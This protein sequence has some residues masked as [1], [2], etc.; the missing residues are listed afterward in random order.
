MSVEDIMNSRSSADGSDSTDVSDK[1][2]PP[3]ITI[4]TSNASRFA[5]FDGYKNK[6]GDS[7]PVP[8]KYSG[9]LKPNFTTK[10]DFNVSIKPDRSVF[11]KPDL[12]IKPKFEVKSDLRNKTD[13][14]LPLKGKPVF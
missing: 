5:I 4:P 6:F 11:I 10:P 8:G 3:S 13:Q 1:W 9:V 14:I 12:S 7:Q 2:Q